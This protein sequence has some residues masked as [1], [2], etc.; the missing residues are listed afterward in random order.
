MVFTLNAA[1]GSFIGM[2]RA[3]N[4]DNFYFNKKRLPIPN[5]GLKN[6]LTQTQTTEEPVV[7]AVFD[8]LGGECRGEEAACLSGEVFSEESKKLQELAISGKEFMYACCEKANAV[9]GQRRRDLQLSSMGTTVAAFY[10]FQKEVVACNVGDSKV[11]RIRDGQMLQISEDHTD[12]K[13]ML[14]MGI[15]KKAVLLQYIGI[16]DSEMAIEPY[17]SK[18]ELEAGDVYILCS[19]GITDVVECAQMYELI[20]KYSPYEA[21]NQIIAEVKKKN[22]SDNATII[23]VKIA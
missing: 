1:C 14:A 7:L 6:P 19:D 17:V 23:V 15:R 22:G 12:E 21:V 18:G 4:E 16:P 20:G 8:G 13:L 10:F 5:H 11:F 9:V 3:T 2:G